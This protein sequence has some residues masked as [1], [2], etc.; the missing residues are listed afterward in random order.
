MSDVMVSIVI[1][2]ELGSHQATLHP[3]QLP[4]TNLESEPL[5][6]ASQPTCYQGQGSFKRS[7]GGY[8]LQS[9][10]EC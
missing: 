7:Y 2:E 6:S 9:C 8:K 1:I 4:R 10:I 3:E 5:L